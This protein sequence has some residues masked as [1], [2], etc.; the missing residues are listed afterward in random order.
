MISWPQHNPKRRPGKNL[1]HPHA[2]LPHLLAFWKGQTHLRRQPQTVINQLTRLQLQP[3]PW[4]KGGFNLR[5]PLFPTKWWSRGVLRA[6]PPGRNFKSRA[7]IGTC[8]CPRWPKICP[9]LS[10]IRQN[11]PS[12]IITAVDF[13]KQHRQWQVLILVMTSPP[14]LKPLRPIAFTP[15]WTT[16]MNLYLQFYIIW[17]QK[18]GARQQKE[19]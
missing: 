19:V 13:M 16:V 5:T 9:A 11:C 3:L 8:F 10:L 18:H 1:Y 15:L 4:K 7:S 12:P 17:Q 2:M 6:K 14:D